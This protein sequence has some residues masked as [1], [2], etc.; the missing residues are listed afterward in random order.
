MSEIYDND[1]KENQKVQKHFL[2]EQK[3]LG[4]LMR[5]KQEKGFSSETMTLKYIL[6]EYDRMCDMETFIKNAFHSVLHDKKQYTERLKWAATT[7]EQNS[8]IIVDVLNTLLLKQFKDIE[9]VIP[10]DVFEAPVIA[11][12]RENIKQKIHHFKQQKDERERKKKYKNAKK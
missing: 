7:A 4:I 11:E 8:Q 5:V 6:N 1:K 12:S 9:D 2:L 10:V 3:E